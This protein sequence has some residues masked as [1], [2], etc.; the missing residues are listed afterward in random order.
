VS[1][2]TCIMRGPFDGSLKWPFQGDVTIRIVNQAGENAIYQKMIRYTDQVSD[3]SCRM[4]DRITSD[5]HGYSQFFPHS[6]LGC[7][8]ARNTQYLLQ[9]SLRIRISKVKPKRQNM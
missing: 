9:D 4:T 3:K 8:A 1:I 7:D 5:G 6:S 2:Y